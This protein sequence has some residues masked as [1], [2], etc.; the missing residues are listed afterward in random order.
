[1]ILNTTKNFA[2]V[3]IPKC[4]GSM[5]KSQLAPLKETGNRYEQ[6]PLHAD[7]GKIHTAHLPLWLVQQMYPDDFK[8]LQEATSYTVVRDPFDRF[9]SALAQRLKQ[10]HDVDPFTLSAD[11]LH[12]EI[13]TVI[14]F[15][16]DNPENPTLEFVHFLPQ[17]AFT[18]LEGRQIVKNIYR[19][20]AVDNMLRAMTPQTGLQFVYALKANQKMNFRLKMLRTPAY[21]ANTLIKTLLPTALYRPLKDAASAVLTKSPTRFSETILSNP[22]YSSFIKAHYKD[23]FELH[24]KALQ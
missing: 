12:R 18:H 16:Q 3:H 7:Y 2:Y 1:M 19:L 9:Q 20:E 13:D 23:D 6:T 24:A 15:L 21:A 5:V 11:E 4:A 14:R 8:A 22:T 17:R 10:F